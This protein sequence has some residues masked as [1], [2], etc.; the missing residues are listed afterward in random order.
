MYFPISS[1]FGR[2]PVRRYEPLFSVLPFLQQ[3]CGKHRKELALLLCVRVCFVFFFGK[4]NLETN[5][6]QSN[7]CTS[8]EIRTIDTAKER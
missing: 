6:I 4:V 5:W 8:K 7:Q 2:R 3:L 1:Q